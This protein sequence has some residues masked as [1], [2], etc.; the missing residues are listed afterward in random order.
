MLPVQFNQLS[1]EVY[2][3][4]QSLQC[5]AEVTNIGNVGMY[6]A[7]Q[8]CTHANTYS[9]TQQGEYS[10]LVHQTVYAGS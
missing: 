4:K 2:L 3:K 10:L 9:C 1:F 7:P 8:T 5:T 6:Y